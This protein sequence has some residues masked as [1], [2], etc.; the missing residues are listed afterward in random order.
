MA[1]PEDRPYTYISRE[2]FLRLTG[3]FGFMAA[4]GGVATACGQDV[5]DQAQQQAGNQA[6]KAAQAEHTLVLSVDGVEDRWPE[7]PVFAPT[8]YHFGT[9]QLKEAIEKQ[10][11]NRIFVD[12]Q[13]GGSLGVGID[14][15]AKVQQGG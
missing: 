5:G 8:M 2:K 7:Q 3:A 1:S 6:E 15:M 9:W 11:D 4:L 10:S 14:L 12:I 13:T